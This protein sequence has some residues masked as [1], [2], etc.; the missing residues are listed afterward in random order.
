MSLI[1]RFRSK[2]G[3]F[4]SNCSPSDSFQVVIDNLIKDKR[5]PN[6]DGL[7]FDI[8]GTEL[9]ATDIAANSVANLS[10][11]NGSMIILKQELSNNNTNNDNTGDIGITKLNIGS[12][13]TETVGISTSGKSI[14]ISIPKRQLKIDD[15]LDKEEGLIPRK[16]SSF[17]RHTDRG[18][19]EYCSPLPPWD[20][21]YK[22]ENNIKHTSFHA[23]LKK[24]NFSVNKESGSSYIP[25]IEEENF[26][27]DNSKCAGSHEP[28]PK[29]ICSKCQPSAITLSLQD[30]RMVDHVEFSN[31]ELINEFINFWRLSGTQ[32]IGLL[33]GR[34]EKYDKVP[35]GIKA[36]IETIYELPQIG[37][38]DGLMLQNWED[39]EVKIT[40]LLEKLGLSI[41]GLIFTDLTDAGNNDGK[42]ICKRHK[43]SYFL[44]SLE[45][46]F[47][48]KWQ[49]KFPNI[50]KWSNTN[51]FSSKFITC[52]ISGN[53]KGE[54]DI[55]SYQI[56]ESGEALVK[57]D[58]ISA[59]SHPAEIFINETTNKRYVPEIFY[60]KK[61]EYNLTVKQNAKP[62]FPVDYLLVSLTHGFPEQPTSD[63][64]DEELKLNKNFFKS[65]TKF[66]IEHRESIGESQL[67]SDIKSYL[68]SSYN[69]DFSKFTEKLSNFHFINYLINKT[70]VLSE[71]EVELVFEIVKKVGNNDGSDG[72]INDEVMSLVYKL[73]DSPGW[74][75]LDTILNYS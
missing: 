10:L 33:I 8:N 72:K 58:L 9:S 42:V 70:S 17:C 64:N 23:Y 69:S 25:P 48:V 53:T 7:S 74:K 54:I 18:M 3:M 41:V 2:Q 30:F 45:V 66:S 14:P 32:R 11:K 51:K 26:K 71:S 34:Y 49:L 28:W 16:R 39:E 5:I 62:T 29:G 27:I 1:L 24:L 19:C 13:N 37:F 36:R 55:T 65:S 68:G 50:C 38:E 63:Q 57:A 44:S 15:D 56:S 75:T 35:L 21:T 43:D 67:M 22:N 59:S 20:E 12:S 52:C 46:L 4:R 60:L 47:S 73:I 6:T 31:S 61:N 40:Q